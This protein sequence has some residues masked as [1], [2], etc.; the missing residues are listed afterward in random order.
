MAG[1]FLAIGFFIALPEEILF[2]GILQ[3]LYKRS[4]DT[5]RAILATNAVFALWHLVPS[6]LSLQQNAVALPWVPAAASQAIG[7]LG[8]LVAVGIGGAAL[9]LLREKTGHLAGSIAVH[10]VA[11]AAMTV[12][13]Y[14]R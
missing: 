9:S 8:S 3:A 6:A 1:R 11:V 10:W 5:T 7:Y 14:L 13:L 4:L 2:R 12:M